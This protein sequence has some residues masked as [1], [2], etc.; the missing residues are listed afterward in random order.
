[1]STTKPITKPTKTLSW[2][3]FY[4]KTDNANKLMDRVW[5]CIA[6]TEKDVGNQHIFWE[7]W[8]WKEGEATKDINA[9]NVIK[10][11]ENHTYTMSTKGKEVD[12][13]IWPVK[14]TSESMKMYPAIDLK[15]MVITPVGMPMQPVLFPS[16]DSRSEFRVDYCEAMGKKM[17][18]VFVLDPNIS[19]ADKEKQFDLLEE[20][21]GVLREWFVDVQ[22]KENYTLGSTGE[23][24]INP[25]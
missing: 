9:K 4:A 12:Y 1:M 5:Y 18:F 16:N 14:F 21:N 6:C 3:E 8:Y 19:K 20:E 25:K 24:D 10:K 7:H 23:P 11:A 17:Y 15:C 13:P 2:Q 22:W